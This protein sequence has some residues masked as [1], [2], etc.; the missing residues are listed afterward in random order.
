MVLPEH[1]GRG[2]RGRAETRDARTFD[3]GIVGKLPSMDAHGAD[4]E[5]G[6]A[7]DAHPVDPSFTAQR[8]KL[9]GPKLIPGRV[10]SPNEG[11][12][13]PE[14]LSR[15]SAVRPAR[16]VHAGCIGNEGGRPVEPRGPELAGPE[17]VSRG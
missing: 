13:L 2:A 4:D 10:E 17:Y 15:K 12:T 3:V 11:G 6:V 5:Q 16:H 14:G 8:S 1:L 9:K 7:I